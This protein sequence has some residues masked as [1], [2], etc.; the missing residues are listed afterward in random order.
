MVNITDLVASSF[1]F[2]NFEGLVLD[3]VQQTFGEQSSGLKPNSRLQ[4][5][6]LASPTADGLA[7]QTQVGRT[8]LSYSGAPDGFAEFAQTTVHANLPV[9]L[10]AKR[11]GT[12]DGI[13][14]FFEVVTNM[15]TTAWPI[16]GALISSPVTFEVYHGG[17]EQAE[18]C[19]ESITRH[20]N[21]ILRYSV[22]VLLS[23]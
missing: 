12:V 14:S 15:S 7:F 23:L 10:V 1:I 22:K 19:L 21:D 9:T 2:F 13:F 5:S 17:P 8:F 16:Q 6:A 20:G 11:V 18:W 3:L 4:W